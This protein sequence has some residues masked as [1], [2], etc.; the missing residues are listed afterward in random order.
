MRRHPLL[1]RNES[2]N[3]LAANWV[4]RHFI[5]VIQPLAL[6]APEVVLG[7]PWDTSADIWNA[8]CLVR[9]ILIFSLRLLL[10]AE[11]D[12]SS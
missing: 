11:L 12:L 6:R 4:D 3:H 7:A 2:N 10:S 5:E 1:Y 9:C 8:A